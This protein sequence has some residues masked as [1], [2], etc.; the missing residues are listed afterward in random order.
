MT[1]TEKSLLDLSKEELTLRRRMKPA[2]DSA[3]EIET[4]R[5]LEFLDH[6]A[7]RRLGDMQDVSGSR[8]GPI[9]HD[10]PEDLDLAEIH[11]VDRLQSITFTNRSAAKAR[12]FRSNVLKRAQ[13]V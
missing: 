6:L 3:E 12:V 2:L 1:E 13:P 8:C 4:Q 11:R 10:D 5:T 7:H 9:G